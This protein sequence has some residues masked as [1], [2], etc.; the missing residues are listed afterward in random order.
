VRVADVQQ[1]YTSMIANPQF[2]RSVGTFTADFVGLGPHLGMQGMIRGR[3]QGP[4]S[5]VAKGA[6]SL[7]VGDYDVNSSRFIFGAGGFQIADRTRLVPVL[8]AELGIRLAPND[9]LSITGGYLVQ[10]WSNIG[11]SGG[12]FGGTFV[13][14]DDSDI[15]SFD[16]LFV[17]GMVN[18]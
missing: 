12:T 6:V 11:T 3:R 5:L 1:S 15:M 9:V 14:T 7:L 8:D 13:Q 4:L 16:G 10:S 18:F 17:R 2:V